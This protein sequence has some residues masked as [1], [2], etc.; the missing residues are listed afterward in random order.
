MWVHR[1]TTF[2]PGRTAP[3]SA[4]LLALL[5]GT[6]GLVN[7]QPSTIA[8]PVPSQ[9]CAYELIEEVRIG[10]LSGPAEHSF[11]EINSIAVAQSGAIYVD[12]SHP[13]S[14]RRFGPDGR[15]V[16]WIGREGEGPGEFRSNAGISV[17]P[18]GRLAAWDR[19]G[20]IT[21]YGTDGQYDE[22]VRVELANP[23]GFPL[24]GPGL[25]H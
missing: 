11:S 6:A 9:E 17:L 13:P 25:P 4:A 12:D 2:F 20:R 7:P 15:F 10:S 24:H 23:W 1:L 19:R 22:L 16:R 5:W 21:V 18:D 3:G 8:V 14:I